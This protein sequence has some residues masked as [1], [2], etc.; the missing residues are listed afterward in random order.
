MKRN[1]PCNTRRRHRVRE[2]AGLLAIGFQE[3]RFSP[4]IYEHTV[5]K[6]RRRFL[7]DRIEGLL[8]ETRPADL[9]QSMTTPSAHRRIT[10][11]R[12]CH[13]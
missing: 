13:S 8:D 10:R 2:E 7:K 4:E 6:W 9:G 5:G 3:F 12:S 11:Q 1:C